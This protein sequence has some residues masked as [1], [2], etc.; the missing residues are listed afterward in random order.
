MTRDCLTPDFVARPFWWDE[1]APTSAPAPVPGRTDVAIVGSGYCGMMAALV[2]GRAGVDVTVLEAGEPGFGASTRNH[3]MTGGEGK[4]PADLEKIVGPAQAELMREDTREATAFIKA[5]IETEAPDIDYVNCG[6]FVAAHC[7]TAYDALLRKAERLR[8]ELGLQVAAIPREAQASEIGTDF[9]HGGITISSGASLQP[10][11]L[12]RQMRRL[13]EA[14][15]VTICGNAEVTQIERL[16]GRYRLRTARGVVEAETAIVATNGY[17][18]PSTPYLR[19]RVVPV[20]P[21]MMATE[22]LPDDLVHEALPTRRTGADTKRALWAFRRSPDGRRIIFGGKARL[23]EVDERAGAE[24]LHGYMSR[25][26]PKLRP[27][28][29]SHGWK[30]FIAFTF[31][32]VPHIGEHD[33]VHFATG[34]HGAGV[35]LMSYLGR[36]L[37][38][39]VLRKQNRPSGFD[40][41]A[42]PTMPLYGGKPWFIPGVTAY[43]NARDSLDMVLARRH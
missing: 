24:R 43:Y 1:A 36:Q 28:R 39:K 10:A 35:S 27:F 37:A 20:I 26:W 13:T 31:D 40:R 30:G 5:F 33:G 3:G 11:K 7:P 29:I 15:G 21:Y 42:F 9:Y 14:A 19:N 22:P 38:L 32:S 23:H 12:Y 8:T 17:T 2:L 41:A 16:P 25:V 4:L 18:G 6:R 34:C